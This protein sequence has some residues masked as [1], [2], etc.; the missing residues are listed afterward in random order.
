[1]SPAGVQTIVGNLPKQKTYIVDSIF[2]SEIADF[3]KNVAFINLNDLENFFNLKSSNR[4]LEIYLKNPKNIDVIKKKL[5][6]I[7][8]DYYVYTW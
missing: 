5:E 4:N 6:K 1:M 2:D 8:Q 3:D 7:F